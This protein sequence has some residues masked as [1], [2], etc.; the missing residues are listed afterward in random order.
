MV[1]PLCNLADSSFVTGWDYCKK[2]LI[3]FLRKKLRSSVKNDSRNQV[4][5]FLNFA[6]NDFLKDTT[7]DALIMMEAIFSI[8]LI[9]KNRTV[10]DS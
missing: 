10:Y 6:K 2:R 3:Q 5:Q 7:K 1:L 9:F 8:F 4:I